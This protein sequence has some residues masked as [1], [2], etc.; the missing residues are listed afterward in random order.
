MMLL[1]N[2]PIPDEGIYHKQENTQAFIDGKDVG[3]GSLFITESEVSWLNTSSQGFG[4]QYPNI[5]LH[6]IS[7]DTTTFPHECL[8][9]M[10]EGKLIEEER[11]E[12]DE[13]E[14][15]DE[16]ATTEVRFV[17]GDKGALDV[18]F[19]AMSDCQTL[20]PDP[21]DSPDSEEEGQFYEG[22]EGVDALTE[23]GQATL[24]RLENML[25]RGQGDN[26]VPNGHN[27]TD[28]QRENMETGQFDDADSM[29]Q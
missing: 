13:E 18:M 10:V 9:L 27:N 8:Y 11:N 19:T 12:D 15:D 1:T 14:E 23:Q 4:L 7:R 6:A 24:E 2:I 5:S 29:E 26:S 22:E 3:N 17:P 16:L 25:Q 28:P 20:H 21:D